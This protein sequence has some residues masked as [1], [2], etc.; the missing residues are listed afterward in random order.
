MTHRYRSLSLGLGLALL[1]SVAVRADA[2]AQPVMLVS[3]TGTN[4]VKQYDLATGAYMG[5]FIPANANVLLTQE[6]L[7]APD[8]TFLVSFWRG[9]ENSTVRRYD[10]DG[11]F[12]GSFTS[13]YS[14]DQPTKMTF[15][16]D[17]DLYVS[18]WSSTQNV[19]VRF[20]GQTGAFD[21]VVADEESIV[22]PMGHAWLPD[23]TL[24]VSNWSQNGETGLVRSYA[25][26]SPTPTGTFAR[27]LRGP[28][29]LF[30]HPS[31]DLLVSDWSQ[32]AVIRYDGATGA[33]KST[34]IS[35]LTRLEGYAIDGNTLYLGEWG[36]NA[37]RKYNLDTGASLGYFISPNTGGLVN[38][39][40]LLIY[41]P[42]AATAS[43]G[44]PDAGLPASTVLLQN[45]PNPFN[46]QTT[47]SYLLAESG[48]V[49]LVVY[50]LF[51]RE[52]A[53][54][55]DGTQAAGAHEATFDATGLPN[56][57]YMARLVTR[58]GSRTRVMTV[59]K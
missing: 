37:V 22:N 54:L 27:F 7:L 29:N 3:S 18:Q 53:T 51:G 38:P 8:G 19:V 33:F 55:V 45:Y 16:P 5:D 57:V 24:L 46:P 39:N 49:T 2:L 42:A 35:G 56:G 36:G 12:L 30:W 17:G 43:D 47:L 32:G 59:L 9:S 48:P 10:T 44:Q 11:S 13:G 50:D 4:S 6:I 41:D 52:T 26:G 15:G 40:S 23:G 20:D 14:L 31:G 28:V 21:A 58:D 1:L 25:Q 34:F